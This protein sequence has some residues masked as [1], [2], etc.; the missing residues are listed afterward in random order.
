MRRLLELAGPV[1]TDAALGRWKLAL[2]PSRY[3]V[4]LVERRLRQFDPDNPELHSQC[5]RVP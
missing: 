4:P 5:A 1:G 2:G 3:D